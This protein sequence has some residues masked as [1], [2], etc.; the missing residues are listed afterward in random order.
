MGGREGEAGMFLNAAG[1][2]DSDTERR[3]ERFI[4]VLRGFSG[5]E[6]K[7]KKIHCDRPGFAQTEDKWNGQLH[8]PYS[9]A[10]DEHEMPTGAM[11]RSRF[12]FCRLGERAEE[13]RISCLPLSLCATGTAKHPVD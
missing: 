3:L 10:A 12:T 6:S 4:L 9:D 11:K 7:K 5:W 1:R 8:S 2:S 13:T